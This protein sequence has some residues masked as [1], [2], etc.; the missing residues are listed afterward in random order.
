MLITAAI[1]VAYPIFGW[2]R[3]SPWERLGEWTFTKWS[4][5]A[6]TVGIIVM[7]LELLISFIVPYFAG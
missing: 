3:T 5:F 6:I 4:A 1:L 2:K 7:V